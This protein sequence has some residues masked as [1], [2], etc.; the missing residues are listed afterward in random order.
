MTTLLIRL[1][2]ATLGTIGFSVFFYVHPRRLLPATLGGCI[3]CAIYLLTN[4]FWGGE[5]IPNFLAAATAAVYAEISARVTR[6]PVPV[7]LMPG[8]I[9]LVPGSALYYTMS[10]LVSEQYRAAATSGRVALQVALGIAGGIAVGSV[11]GLFLHPRK[12]VPKKGS[13]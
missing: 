1:L 3:S 2:T 12:R 7:Y 10:N 5:L 8:V 13:T 9:P 11:W 6:V 4:Y